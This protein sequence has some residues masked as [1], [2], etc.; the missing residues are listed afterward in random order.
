MAIL[1]IDPGPVQSAAVV[2]TTH[3]EIIDK[4]L[5]CNEDMLLFIAKHYNESLVIE[6]MSS[7]GQAVGRE[8]FETC[9]WIGRFRQYWTDLRF[10]D[11]LPSEVL[12]PTRKEVLRYWC[13][14][15]DSEIIEAIVRLWGGT[16]RR[17]VVGT[18]R[19]PGPLYGIKRDLWQALALGMYALERGIPYPSRRY[20]GTTCVTLPGTINM[21]GVTA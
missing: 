18:D 4:Y 1:A 2:L 21:P 14:N 13:C 3:R 6:M 7:Y 19:K 12:L 5:A 8:I 9:V 20:S 10:L 15:N 17:A 11:E 16:S